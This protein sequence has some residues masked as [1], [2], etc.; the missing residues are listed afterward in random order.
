MKTYRQLVYLVLDELKL[1]SDDS[2]YTEDH[3]ISLLSTYRSFLWKQ[4]YAD[5]RKEIPLENY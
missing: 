4:R 5:V 2:T 3:V 1:M